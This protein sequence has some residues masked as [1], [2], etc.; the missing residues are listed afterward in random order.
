M[1]FIALTTLSKEGTLKK[2]TVEIIFKKTLK[3]S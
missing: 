3:N 1:T 2:S